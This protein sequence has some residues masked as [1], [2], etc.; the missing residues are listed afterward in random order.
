M[1][2]MYADRFAI[3]PRR[4]NVC[5]RLFWLEPYYIF[6]KVV[7]I[8]RFPLKQIRCKRCNKKIKECE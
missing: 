7:G 8:E 2:I 1:T 4:C 6:Y 5:D 3:V